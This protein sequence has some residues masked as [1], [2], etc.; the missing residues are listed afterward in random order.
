MKNISLAFL[1]LISVFTNAQGLNFSTQEE[2]SEFKKLTNQT[3]GFTADVPFR[4]SFEEYVPNVVQQSGSTCV[5]YATL[6]YGLSTMYNIKFNIRDGRGKLAHSFDPNYIYTILN[7]SILNPCDEGLRMY[8][9]TEMLQKIGAKKLLYPPYLR[10]D[11]RW[12][13]EKLLPVLDYTLPYAINDF[14]YIDMKNPN[15]VDLAKQVLYYDV[16][17]I[18]GF[19]ITESLYPYSS[20]NSNGVDSTGLWTPI[21][22]EDFIG[23]HAMTLVGYDD[24]KYGGAFRVVNSWGSDYGDDGFI[25]IR[26]SDWVKYAKESYILELKEN[27]ISNDPTFDLV[28][29]DYVRIKN[30]IGTYEGQKSD[31]SYI[32]GLGVFYNKRQDTHYIGNFNDSEMNGYILFLDSDGLFSS[33]VINGEFRDINQL[34]FSGIQ[35]F[36][37]K[38]DSI[39]SYF[40]EIGI[41]YKVRKANSTKKFS[42]KVED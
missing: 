42:T 17:I 33:N 35:N 18:S 11:T 10:C 19:Y 7:N 26:Y 36:E 3:Y 22:I 12:T 23:G 4:Y 20:S 39:N 30:N 21:E 31:Y 16:P 2:L 40:N 13:E 14:I 34:G 9:A 15:I 29:N 37:K 1:L 24:Y 5:G 6:Y 41:K 8:E 28:E 32:D 38:N 25:W 27:I